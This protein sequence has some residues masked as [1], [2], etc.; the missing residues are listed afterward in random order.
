MIRYETAREKSILGKDL[1]D[2]DTFYHGTYAGHAI[3]FL[4]SFRGHDFSDSE[5]RALC[6][7]CE[8]E[9]HNLKGKYGVYAVR[10]AL[11]G[12]SYFDGLMA[13]FRKGES[14]RKLSF[15]VEEVI[16]N[17]KDFVF[18]IGDCKKTANPVFMDE[19]AEQVKSDQTD[20]TKT[21][22]E[23]DLDTGLV[24][25]EDG[26]VS[27]GDEFDIPEDV[28]VEIPEEPVQDMKESSEMVDDLVDT[29][30]N[31]APADTIESVDA[32]MDNK[33]AQSD[34]NKQS[35]H[36][37]DFRKTV[38][39]RPKRL[40]QDG[41]EIVRKKVRQTKKSVEQKSEQPDSGEQVILTEDGVYH[42][43]PYAVFSTVSKEN[44]DEA[45]KSYFEY[46]F[47]KVDLPNRDDFPSQAMYDKVLADW[48]KSY[49]LAWRAALLPGE[50]YDTGDELCRR[51]RKSA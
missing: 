5:C 33:S 29:V 1:L 15:N 2:M 12:D 21:P 13:K 41:T 6:D 4:K 43:S 35:E 32:G 3:C 44:F 48:E 7:G 17:N 34:V 39:R 11:T 28:D 14:E 31:G 26:N 36:A 49:E 40:G 38:S 46:L 30:E 42:G 20:E 47:E 9:I 18:Y 22:V 27:Y 8:I 19:E 25:D 45:E 50:D 51:V 24:F 10:G 23:E 16:P 37:I